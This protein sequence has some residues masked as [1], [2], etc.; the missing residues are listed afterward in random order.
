VILSLEDIE[1]TNPA[2]PW[3][4]D[5]LAR[6]LEALTA[7]AGALTPSPVDAPAAATP[8]GSDHWRQLAAEPRQS[9]CC[10]DWN[11][12]CRRTST[13]SSSWRRHRR[14][15]RRATPR[16]LLSARWT[17][18]QPLGCHEAPPLA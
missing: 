17:V 16:R 10:Q 13:C 11:P 6:V 2:L 18:G 15:P 8:G 1:G 12:G 7:T 3:H 9:H 14:R 4:Y 5:Q